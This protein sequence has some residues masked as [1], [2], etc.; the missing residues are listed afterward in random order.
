MIICVLENTVTLRK[1][2][3]YVVKRSTLIVIASTLILIECN[4]QA[5]TTPIT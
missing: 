4:Y 3:R 2:K 1:P 5:E